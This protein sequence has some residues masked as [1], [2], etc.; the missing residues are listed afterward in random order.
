MSLYYTYKLDEDDNTTTVTNYNGH[1]G[2]VQLTG[3][4]LYKDNKWNTL[5]LPFDVEDGDT[6]DNLTFTGTPLAGAAVKELQEAIYD[7]ATGSLTLNFEDATKI[8]AGCPYLIKWEGGNDLTSSDLIF[9]GVTINSDVKDEV[10]E[11][12]DTNAIT[13]MG[14]YKQVSFDGTDRSVLYLGSNNMLYYPNAAMTIGAQRA[15]FQLTGLTAGDVP[16]GIS[17]IKAFV[18]NFG[19]ESTGIKE[20]SSPSNPS[21][22]SNL[23]YTLDGRRLSDMPTQR[24]IYINNGRKIMIK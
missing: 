9:K 16:S 2:N 7:P 3:R 5:C 6:D 15:Y 8:K 23:W 22:L 12:D 24:G 20:I 10:C 19:D 14:T 21:N 17:G 1:S 13:F 18:L 11:I 4:T